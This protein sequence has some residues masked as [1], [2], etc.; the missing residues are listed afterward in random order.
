MKETPKEL[1]IHQNLMSGTMSIDGFLGNDERH[2]HEIIEADRNE[3]KLLDIS[4]DEIADRLEYFTDKAFES[5]DGPVIIDKKYK[6]FYDSFRG[7]ILCPFDHPGVYRKGSIT[8]KNLQNDLEVCWTPLNIHL[9]REHC[10]FE[11]K[12]STH[13]LEPTIL[14]KVLF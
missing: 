14:S 7:K 12:G 6:V 11:G 5:Y 3:L 4:T 2:F 10:F 1:K 8:L 13:R 9:I